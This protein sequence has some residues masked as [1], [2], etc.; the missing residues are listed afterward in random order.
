[1]DDARL[2]QL[3]RALSTHAARSSQRDAQM[4]EAAVALLIRP[5]EQ[6][7]LLLIKRAVHERDPWSGHVALPGGR[8]DAEDADL[9]ETAM[10]ETS[11]EVGVALDRDNDFIATLDE[12]A[13]RSPRLP[14]IVIAPFIFA[15]NPDTHTTIDTRE[16]EAAIWVPLSALRDESA[17]SEILIELEGGSRAFPSLQ[18]GDYVIWGLTHR[19]LLQFLDLTVGL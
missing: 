12:V 9:L 10:R 11:E 5:R 4:R 17:A 8:R 13:P 7:E 2:I 15:V 6:L 18:Y 16:V 3:R 1:M 19:I 14:P